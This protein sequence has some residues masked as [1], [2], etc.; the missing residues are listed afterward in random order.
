MPQPSQPPGARSG[1]VYI[2]ARR[3]RQK[4]AAFCKI[5]IAPGGDWHI[6]PLAGLCASPDRKINAKYGCIYVI[7]CQDDKRQSVPHSED[8]YRYPI[9][10]YLPT[11]R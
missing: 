11:Y 5:E 9:D 2:A 1:V 3:R 8:K 4:S 10:T 7:R 6:V